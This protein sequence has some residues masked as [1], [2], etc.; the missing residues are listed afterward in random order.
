MG[1]YSE[2]ND[3]VTGSEDYTI[4]GSTYVS[5]TGTMSTPPE[6]QEFPNVRGHIVTNWRQE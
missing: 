6:T 5:W 3:V 4:G 1:D 2:V